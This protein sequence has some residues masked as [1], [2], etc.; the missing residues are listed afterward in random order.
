MAGFVT[1]YNFLGYRLLEP[2]F[3]LSQLLVGFVF[4]SYL[5][6]TATAPRA[7]RLGADF[8]L[9]RGGGLASVIGVAT[10]TGLSLPDLAGPPFAGGKLSGTLRFGGSG[11]STAAIVAPLGRPPVQ[12][13][14]KTSA[15]GRRIAV[16]AVTWPVAVATG[17]IPMA[18]KRRP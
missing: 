15:S 18:L 4:V 8:A 5:A 16:E 12:G 1:V 14:S 13:R 10:A 17:G 2:P 3:G 7:G 9:T 11:E 6:G